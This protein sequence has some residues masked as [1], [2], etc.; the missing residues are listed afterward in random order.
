MT[1]LAID[2]PRRRGACPGLS[3]PMPTGDGL[4]VRLMP[5]GTI[6]LEAFGTLCAAARQYGNGI[7]EITGR[8]SIQLR[9]LSADSAPRFTDAIVALDIAA[10]GI[11]VLSNPLAG[12]DSEE[13]L[14]AGALAADLRRALVR[15]SLAARLAPKT[16]VVIDGG[17]A[18]DLNGLAADVRLCAEATIRGVA[19]RVGVGGDAPRATQLGAVAPNNGGEAA[20]RLLDVIAQHGRDVRARDILAA[21]GAV[22]FRSALADIL[23]G[24]A[25]P[26]AASK[27]R[28]A[29]GPHVLRDGSLAYGI[30][31]AFGHADTAALEQ[32]AAAAGTAGAIGIRAAPARML[33]IVG[34][35]QEVPSSFVTAAERLGFIVCTDDPRRHVT[36]CAGAPICSS[37]HVAARAIAPVIAQ[38]SASQLGSLTIHVSGCAKGCAHPAAAALTVVGTP[39]GCALIA[40]G[41]T[42]DIPFTVVPTNELPAAI[43]NFTREREASHV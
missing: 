37:A 2:A 29:I 3:A 30:G 41:S 32:L 10:D 11:P 23:I 13:I 6:P 38:A 42:R 36:A 34:L 14:D 28:E 19:L 35:K 27:S 4:L 8:G 43:A 7:V 5:V 21:E 24:D 31:L 22:A 39:S 20:M 1:A 18:L 33:M 9:G 40:D 17:G 26:T 16:S 15:R 12:L 25:S